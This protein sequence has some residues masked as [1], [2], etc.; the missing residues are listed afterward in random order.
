[1]INGRWS[2]F[3]AV[4]E[5]HVVCAIKSELIIVTSGEL[6][7]FAVIRVGYSS[8]AMQNADKLPLRSHPNSENQLSWCAFRSPS[9]ILFWPCNKKSK[10]G[11][12]PERQAATGGMYI[13]IKYLNRNLPERTVIHCISK[14]ASILSIPISSSLKLTELWIRKTIPPPLLIFWVQ[15]SPIHAP[16]YCM[17]LPRF[18]G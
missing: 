4:W 12:Y 13:D 14:W 5:F 10:V 17:G 15:Y 11:L 8:F 7:Q 18:Q 3:R 1:M 9:M 16:A 2:E 6:R